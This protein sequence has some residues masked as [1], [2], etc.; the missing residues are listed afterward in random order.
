MY[1]DFR[2]DSEAFDVQLLNV[3]FVA[4][5]SHNLSTLQQFTA[6]NHTCF[7]NKDGVELR[8]RSGRILKASKF[9]RANVL[10]GFCVSTNDKALLATVNPGVRPP[11]F[12]VSV[13]INDFNCSFSLV[14]EGR[15]GETAKPPNATSI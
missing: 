10:R 6:S 15:L 7:G 8:F 12:N 5:L 2:S 9:G 4:S 11:N 14:H 13:D 1:V 3:A